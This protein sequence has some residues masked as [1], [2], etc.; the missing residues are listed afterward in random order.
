MNWLRPLFG[1]ILVGALALGAAQ[2]QGSIPDAHATVALAHPLSELVD[3]ADR[4]VVG[5]PV[6]K[7]SRWENHAGKRI[8]T[9]TKI[10]VDSRVYGASD[11]SDSND[12]DKVVWV[13]TLGGAV[14]G[15]GQHVAGQARLDIGKRALLFL[16]PDANLLVVSGAAQ[17]HFPLRAVVRKNDKGEKRTTMVLDAS[18]A[19]GKLVQ[20]PGPSVS[21]QQ[22]LLG[23]PL[24][25]AVATI[26]K[27][28]RSR[29]DAKRK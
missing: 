11:D 23:R 10:A 4:V 27:A 13:R 19:A 24:N 29:D 20:R 12:S 2:R 3:M 22:V 18:P 25:E 5:T 21:A 28:R 8:V 1:G 7:F 26:Q 6:E 17:G 9:Y 15:V 14:E 16:Q